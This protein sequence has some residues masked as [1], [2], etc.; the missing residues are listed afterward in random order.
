MA[1]I[2]EVTLNQ[3]RF[4][5]ATIKP[6]N[7]PDTLW[8]EYTTMVD[9]TEDDQPPVYRSNTYRLYADSDVSNQEDLV[10]RLHAAAFAK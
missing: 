5:K 1:I 7:E 2:R 9:D 3:I 6:I 8:V 4:T 10:K